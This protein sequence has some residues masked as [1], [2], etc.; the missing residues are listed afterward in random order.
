MAEPVRSIVF[1]KG[2]VIT[3]TLIVPKGRYTLPYCKEGTQAQA[4]HT[5]KNPA[6]SKVSIVKTHNNIT[7]YLSSIKEDSLPDHNPR[8]YLLNHKS[9][10]TTTNKELIEKKHLI[11][12]LK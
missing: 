11:P 5:Q 6:K 4:N 1:L 9:I 3:S 2:T 8:I 7:K 10:T 12:V